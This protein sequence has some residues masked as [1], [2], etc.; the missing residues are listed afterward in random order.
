MGMR[1]N[2]GTKGRDPRRAGG[3]SLAVIH[4]VVASRHH[5]AADSAVS[6]LSILTQLKRRDAFRRAGGEGRDGPA[7][8]SC[9]RRRF[10]EISSETTAPAIERSRASGRVSL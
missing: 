1:S 10:S 3:G 8:G 2:G 9:R 7:K 4:G 5:P 6:L